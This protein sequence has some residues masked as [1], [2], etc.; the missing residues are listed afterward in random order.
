MELVAA[1]VG[2]LLLCLV[3]PLVWLAVRRVRLMRN[4][5]VDLCLRRRF[6]VTD[7][8]FGVGRYEGE[9][10]A[11][12]RLTSF[13]IGPTVV[14]DRAQLE[15]VDRRPPHRSE[16]FAIPMAVEVLRFHARIPGGREGDVELAMS[17]DVRTGFLAWIE[18]TPPGRNGFREAS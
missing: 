6:A 3:V 7:W 9:R 17:S 15:I 5:G 16:E 1:I 13:R 10:F 18:A 2:V 14:L 4:G 11:W 12:Y 8:H